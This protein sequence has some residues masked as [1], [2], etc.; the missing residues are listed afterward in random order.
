MRTTILVTLLNDPRAVRCVESAL[1]QGSLVEEVLVAD[2]GSKPE[3]LAPLQDLAKRERRVR[4]LAA[5]GSVA[6][7]RNQALSEIRTDIVAFLDAD[8]V[9]PPGWLNALTSPI[10]GGDAE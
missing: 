2:G 3:L 9:A 4:I 7:S 6:A 1:A 10:R 8:E 5:P